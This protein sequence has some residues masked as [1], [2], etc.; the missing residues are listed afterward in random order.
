MWVAGGANWFF[1]RPPENWNPWLQ[2]IQVGLGA[3]LPLF[4]VKV[5]VESDATSGPLPLENWLR[6][7]VLAR[8][9]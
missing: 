3:Y 6:E 2:L 4:V 8:A 7:P 5:N 9:A 1:G